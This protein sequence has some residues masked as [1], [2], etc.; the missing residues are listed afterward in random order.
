MK[1]IDPTSTAAWQELQAHLQ[2]VKSLHLRD[3]FKQNPERTEQFTIRE[4]GLLLDYSKN[5]ITQQSIT[6]LVE[7]AR[8]CQLEEAIQLMFSG[9]KI[10]ETEDRAVLH[11]ALRNSN[12]RPIYVNQKDILPQIRS[13]FN[14]MEEIS[15]KIR[16]Q[17]W[18][19]F[20]GKPIRT[21]VHLGIGGSML[22][23]QM[24]CQALKYYGN[25][26]INNHFIANLDAADF[27]ETMSTIDVEET[28]FIVV[29]KTFTTLETLNNARLA[30][31]K[32]IS[33]FKDESALSRHLLAVTANGPGAEAFGIKRDNIV[34]I[35]DWIGGRFSLASAVGLSIMISI[36][37][38]FFKQFLQGLSQMD[39]HFQQ[40]PLE[41]NMPV[42]L[43]LLGIW[44][45]NF[46]QAHSQAVLPY[47][48]YLK[49]L[50]AY[51]QA[52]EMESNGKNIDRQG[53]PTTYQT[54]AI[55]WG[56]VGTNGQHAFFQALHQGTRLI[57]CDFIG[58]ID[59]LH[60][61]LETHKQLLAN[62]IAQTESLAHGRSPQK[63]EPPGVNP[64]HQFSGNRPSNLLLFTKLTPLSL[65]KLVSLYEHK[66]FCQGIIWNIFSFDQWGVELGKQMAGRIYSELGTQGDGP[67]N[68]FDSS[69]N[70]II[71]L[72]KGRTKLPA[73]PEIQK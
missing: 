50:P 14:Q 48:H 25:R 49:H 11:T 58:F 31:E 32:I 2:Q 54:S 63:I 34:P 8:Q 17:Q 36:G 51:L 37:P 71:E 39:S 28:L 23:P 42:I 20:S 33:H 55:V 7:L 73:E 29:S 13:S 27:N 45:N 70:R 65:G 53:K 38:D 44:Y 52:L 41:K 18:P 47:C 43:A 64:F 21:I 24:V 59:P 9:E 4:P 56:D 68:S 16:Q 1:H 72:F 61:E 10:N 62:L 35:W 66:V 69:T 22:G 67:I 5:L 26:E 57:P 12:D 46:F 6:S 30:R 40:A 60:S 19:G 3:L 15:R